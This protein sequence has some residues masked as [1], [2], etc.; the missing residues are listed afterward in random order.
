MIP[1]SL[2]MF[3]LLILLMLLK[4]PVA[5]A[6]LLTSLIFILSFL[7]QRGLYLVVNGFFNTMANWAFTA[8]VPFIFMSALMDEC[9][10]G[11]DMFLALRK[12]FGVKRSAFIVIA[13]IISYMISMMS[14]AVVSALSILALLVYP[15]MIKAG[16][17]Q[18]LAVG[19][20]IA[21]GSLPQLIPPSL[22][23]IMYGLYTETSIGKLF[24]GGFGPGTLMAVFFAL[25]AY[26]YLALKRVT[27]NP[28]GVEVEKVP[29][30]EKVKALKDFI[31][32]FV[33][34]VAT[35]GSIYRGIATPTE[36]ASVG[37]IVTLAY[38]ILRRRL[39]FEKLKKCLLVTLRTTSFIFFIVSAS[40]TFGATFSTLG[41]KRAVEALVATFPPAYAPILTIALALL[42]VFLAGMFM[43]TFSIVIIFGPLFH[44]ILRGFGYDPVWWGVVFCSTLLT[45]FITPPVGMS[46]FIFKN[47]RPE[48]PWG[49]IVRSVWP[50]C[51]LMALAT[52]ISIIYPEVVMFFVRLL[53][54]R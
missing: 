18:E 30:I 4:I 42:V 38:V 11:V 48:V 2:A 23:M 10:L 14:G 39:T 24:A 22:N 53:T 3:V 26:A 8:V 36:A 34:I 5:F 19:F 32:P 25:Y 31:G 49:T 29:L 6:L 21:T 52:A 17:P 40:I 45:G 12:I 50:Y 20:L 37:A 44:S 7:G 16:F 46:L 47:L 33:I 41:G 35:L 15:S 27:L 1:P 13:S 43:E 28:V 51:G 54:R 9:G